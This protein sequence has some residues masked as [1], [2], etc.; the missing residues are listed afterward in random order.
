[1]GST[2][3]TVTE[4]AAALRE[5]RLV[6]GFVAR[7]VVIDCRFDLTSPEAGEAAYL[8]AH[9]PGAS[10]AHLERHLAGPPTT[11][12][13]RHPLPSPARLVAVFESFGIANDTRV[14][15]YDA[16]GGGLAAAR[17]WWLLRYMG[18]ARVAV[19]DGGWQAWVAAHQPVMRGREQPQQ[20]TFVGAPQGERRVL[21]VDDLPTLPL[22]DARDPARY[23]GEIE[24]L[25]P[26]AGHIPGARNHFWRL[27]LDADGR[28]RSPTALREAFAASLG[29]LPDAATVHYCGSGV[30]ACHNVLAQVHAGLPEPR[31]YCGS[32]S[33]WCRD[34]T[35]PI[36]SGVG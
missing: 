20:A 9:V 17:L 6:V 12:H 18:H 14:V 3:V 4:L 8:E 28:F 24:P 34:P 30:T 23:R 25:D 2:L 16:A 33:E 1:M 32:W 35:R 29:K 22:V 7:L 5:P 11:D 13:G 31:V 19:L 26:R 15:A 10:Y 27:N 21:L 36:A